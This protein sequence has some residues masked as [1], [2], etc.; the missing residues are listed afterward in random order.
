MHTRF[1]DA[2]EYSQSTTMNNDAYMPSNMKNA[3][4]N[5]LK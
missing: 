2:I 1:M 3:H 4:L 5:A